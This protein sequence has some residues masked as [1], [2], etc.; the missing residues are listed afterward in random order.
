MATKVKA[1][2]LSMEKV[3]ENVQKLPKRYRETA[4]DILNLDCRCRHGS[5]TYARKFEDSGI[6]DEA[7][8]LMAVFIA[9]GVSYRAAEVIFHL[10]PASGNDVYRCVTNILKKNRDVRKT[11]RAI[12]K[13]HDRTLP[14]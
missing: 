1:E 9:Y 10:L 2:P 3:L 7:R 12:A 14:V 13:K 4:M 11:C 6:T 8:E 5:E